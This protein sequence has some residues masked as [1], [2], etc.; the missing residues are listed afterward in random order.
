MLQCSSSLQ[1]VL[2]LLKSGKL[3]VPL[4]EAAVLEELIMK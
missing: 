3:P 2:L 1:K 4:P